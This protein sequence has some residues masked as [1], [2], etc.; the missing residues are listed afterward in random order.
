MLPILGS[1]SLVVDKMRVKFLVAVALSFSL[2]APS[3]VWADEIDDIMSEIE[4]GEDVVSEQPVAVE[5]D[6]DNVILPEIG[7]EDQ[8]AVFVLDRGFYFASDLGVLINL[9]G[10]RGNSNIQPFISTVFGY[11]VNDIFSG[12]VYLAQGYVSQNPL[13][14]AD[15]PSQ[16][17]GGNLTADYSLTNLGVSGVAAWRPT[18]RFALEGNVGGG[19]TRLNPLLTK[20]DLGSHA[21]WAPHVGGGFDLKYLTLLTDFTAGLSVN[22]FFV[23]SPQ[24][25]AVS[26]SGVVRYTF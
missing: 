1:S 3:V 15:D 5:K 14:A 12:E 19:V 2:M 17:L 10:T 18:A 25:L 11:D 23:I 16:G 21:A 13:T 9:G 22:G 8:L 20:A 4:S 7:D 26:A 24:I 6:E